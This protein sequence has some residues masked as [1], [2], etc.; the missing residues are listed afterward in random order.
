MSSTKTVKSEES[1]LDFGFKIQASSWLESTFNE[2]TDFHRFGVR[3]IPELSLVRKLH[4]GISIDSDISYNVLGAIK[5]GN[6]DSKTELYRL[7]LRLITNRSDFRIGLQKINFG[8]AQLLRSLRWF[9]QIDPRDPTGQTDGLWGALYRRFWDNNANLWV[10]GLCKNEDLKGIDPFPTIND[11]MEFGGRIQYPVPR[12]EIGGTFHQRQTAII[13]HLNEFYDRDYTERRFALDGRW[14]IEIGF[15]FEAAV[16]NN[17]HKRFPNRWTKLLTIGIDYTIPI[18]S[19]LFCTVE[20][21]SSSMT[22]KLFATGTDYHVSALMMNIPVS[23]K[24]TPMLM[25]YWDWDRKKAFLYFDWRRNYETIDLHLNVFKYPDSTG[26]SGLSNRG[27]FGRGY[28]GG[29][30]VVWNH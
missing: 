29:V 17:E 16:I 12:G 30:M 15:W 9:D 8:P 11:E 3:F 1:K 26:L 25:G 7:K 28:G 20:N 23:F 13:D 21:F 10:W 18:A 24:D 27:G 19:G 4:N 2:D 22:D 5:D 14:D 6:R